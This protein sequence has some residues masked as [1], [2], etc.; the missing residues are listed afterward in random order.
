MASATLPAGTV[1]SS[2][3]ADGSGLRIG[4]DAGFPVADD[5]LPPCPWTGV[6]HGVTV[7][8]GPPP[9][10]G[11]RSQVEEAVHRD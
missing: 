10:A 9:G 3:Q 7:E 4:H 1:V 8:A 6:I 5:Y 11:L 2:G